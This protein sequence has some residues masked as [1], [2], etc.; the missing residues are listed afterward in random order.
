MLREEFGE[1]LAEL[2]PDVVSPALRERLLGALDA[3]HAAGHAALVEAM[4]SARH[5][6]LLSALANLVVDPPVLPGAAAPASAVL[7][8][9]LQR[10]VDR[11]EALYDLAEQ[12]PR[13]LE[14]WHEVRK[15]AKAVRYCADSL[16]DAFGEPARG[17]AKAW[18][19]VTEAFGVL[20]DAVVARELLE[21]ALGRAREAGEPLGPYRVLIEAQEDRRHRSL[22]EG[23]EA[24]DAALARDVAGL[25][26]PPMRTALG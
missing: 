26:A 20:Q 1:L 5:A 16:T 23:R 21:D 25:T 17:P 9:L 11:V 24:L 12:R 3:Q 13:R 6:D 4:G 22:A 8:P 10:A 19:N 18:K 2:G 14:R 15:A 7:P